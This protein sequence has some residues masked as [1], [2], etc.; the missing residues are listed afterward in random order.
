MFGWCSEPAKDK[1]EKALDARDAIDE[2]REAESELYEQRFDNAKAKFEGQLGVIEHEKNV[3]EEIIAHDENR[4]FVIST[5][6]YKALQDNVHA[7]AE[8]MRAQ[9]KEML[10]KLN[11]GVN[12]GAIEVGSEKWYAMVADIDEVTESIYECK[13]A[14]WEYWKAIQEA[15]WAVFDMIQDKISG[16]TK[17]SEFLIELMSNKKLYDDKGQLTDEGKATMGLHGVNYN[18]HMAQADKYAEEIK[19]L[20]ELISSDPELYLDQDLIN[21]RQ[22]L[23]ELQQES[24]LNAEDEKNAIKDMVEEGIQ[25]ELDAL[26]ELINKYTEALETQKDLYD[27]QKKVKD[28]TEEIA[29][30]E[31]QLAA[32]QGDDSE[33][34]RQ[35]LQELK[36]ELKSSKEDL[37]ELEYDQYISDQKKLL[38]ELYTE[39]E[40]ILNQRLDNIDQLIMDMIT[41]INNNSAII[42]DTIREQADNVGYTVSESMDTIFTS[43]MENMSGIITMYGDGFN[44]ALTTVNSALNNI[45]TNI[46]DMIAHIDR[47]ANE[48][49][50]EAGNSSAA[51]SPEAYPTPKPEPEPQPQP[52]PPKEITVGGMINAGG[53]WI[54]ADSGGGGRGTQYYKNDPIYTVLSERNG[55][56]L[57]RHHTMSSGYTGW[58]WK[59]DVSAYATGKKRIGEDEMAWTQER[60]DEMIVR[61]SDGAILTPLA[62]GDS[63]LNATATGNIWDMANSP[64]DFIRDNLSVENVGAP[65]QTVAQAEYTQ[66]IDNVSFVMP[67]VRNYEQMLSAM[68]K[69]KNFQRLVEAMTVD[70]IAGGSSLRKGKAI[71]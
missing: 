57:V 66:N 4:G 27:Y 16:I 2:L 62:K 68:Q 9:K 11:E 54:Y 34:N 63:V 37:E 53:A 64:A 17:E 71:R 59:G 65:I 19:K 69:D 14:W 23:L 39:Y 28:A 56:L 8:E 5:K 12:S 50:E 24:I 55:Y 40:T 46:R 29:A 13:T 20:D 52:E 45:N 51:N 15:D 22:E 30:L 3:L 26:D 44:S 48:R 31:K 35:K 58:F 32:L 6:Y 36:E 60:G 61:P 1:D 49:V 47:I 33:E 67:N 25:L 21:R 70:K 38:D 10:E 18:V 41:E 7:Q 42:G 43:N